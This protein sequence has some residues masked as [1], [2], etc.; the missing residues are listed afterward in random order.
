LPLVPVAE[1]WQLELST[2]DEV[3]EISISETMRELGNEQ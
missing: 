2:I 1:F 3:R